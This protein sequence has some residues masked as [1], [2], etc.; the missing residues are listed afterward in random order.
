MPKNYCGAVAIIMF[1]I[2]IVCILLMSCSVVNTCEKADELLDEYQT[3][4]SKISALNEDIYEMTFEYHSL[5]S[6]AQS[7]DE[8][9]IFYRSLIDSLETKAGN[10]KKAKQKKTELQM[11]EIDKLK[12]YNYYHELCQ[13]NE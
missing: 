2:A 12:W 6:M 8:N 3:I 7:A 13:K 11:K 5:T 10:L 4:K 1:V 9:S